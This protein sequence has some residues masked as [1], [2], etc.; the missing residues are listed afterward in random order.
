MEIGLVTCNE[1]VLRSLSV[2]SIYTGL[3]AGRQLF[4]CDHY[5]WGS[6]VGHAKNLLDTCP[7]LR[8]AE[9]TLADNHS[10]PGPPEILFKI[11][12]CS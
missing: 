8:I 12:H 2:C 11:A 7:Q 9:A 5:Y 3:F 4:N 6:A 10:H 1:S